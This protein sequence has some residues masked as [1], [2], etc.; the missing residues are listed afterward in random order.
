MEMIEKIITKMVPHLFLSQKR[1]NKGDG[2]SEESWPINSNNMEILSAIKNDKTSDRYSNFIKESLNT[3]ISIFSSSFEIE[4][5]IVLIWLKYLYELNDEKIIRNIF[6]IIEKLDS[7]RNENKYPIANFIILNNSNEENLNLISLDNMYKYLL[8][9]QFSPNNYI[10]LSHNA[11]GMIDFGTIEN[12]SIELKTPLPKELKIYLNSNLNI[13]IGLLYTGNGDVYI[14][15]NETLMSCRR[16]Q[17]WYCH[18]FVTLQ[19]LFVERYTRKKIGKQLLYIALQ[20][21]YQKKGGLIIF[22]PDKKQITIDIINTNV[23]SEY[24]DLFKFRT[25]RESLLK[26]LKI[27][28][29]DTI[30]INEQKIDLFID[31]VSLDG[32]VVLHEK[33]GLKHIGG[34]IGFPNHQVLLNIIGARN[35]SS[36]YAERIIDAITLKISQNGTITLFTEYNKEKIILEFL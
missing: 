28:N 13:K 1:M 27:F 31:L 18:D 20:L 19:K 21:S 36:V 22:L 3:N 23:S 35:A 32:C 25:I 33:E 9:I 6:N 26:V 29:K 4:K 7:A 34:L 30:Q 2:H 5:N 15:N 12:S 11:N 8:G 10:Q 17:Q 24:S 14:I 16:N